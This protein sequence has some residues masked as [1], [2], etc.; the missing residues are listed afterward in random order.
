MRVVVVILCL[1]TVACQQQPKKAPG[2]APISFDGAG[3][4]AR[5]AML[6]HGE[7]LTHVLGCTGCHGAHLEGTFLTKDEPQYGPIYASNLTVEVPEYTNAQ[8]DGIIRHGTHPERKAVWAMPSQIFQHLS[9]P[10]FKA[11]IAFLR[12]LK[13]QGQSFSPPQFSVQDKKDIAAGRYKPAAQMVGESSGVLPVTP[14][15]IACARSLHHRGDLCRMSRSKIGGRSPGADGA[16]SQ[17]DRRRGLFTG[18]IRAA[19]DARHRDRQPQDQSCHVRSCA[20]PLFT[21]HAARTRCAL[22]LSQSPCGAFLVPDFG[23]EEPTETDAVV[24]VCVC[25]SIASVPCSSAATR[26]G[27]GL[28]A[29]AGAGGALGWGAADTEEATAA[30]AKWL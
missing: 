19:D 28:G 24:P 22:C 21:L 14:R 18:P 4:T 30:N 8:L 5:A 27:S 6:T 25:W 29:G 26:G 15:T 17:P 9:D 12:T 1:A 23:F 7:R 2:S 13:P 16:N 3:A 20:H 10:D 11:L